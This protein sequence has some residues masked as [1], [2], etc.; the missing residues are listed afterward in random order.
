M[1]VKMT[2]KD[3]SFIMFDEVKRIQISDPNTFYPSPPV[4][5]FHY[6][7]LEKFLSKTI[8]PDTQLNSEDYR[9][10]K[11]DVAIGVADEE[12]PEKRKILFSGVISENERMCFR[13]V[14]FVHDDTNYIL[15][16]QHPV[17]ICSDAGKTIEVV[18]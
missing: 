16:T 5:C 11:I 17:Y 1:L 7:E 12:V 15:Y 3:G 14:K 13:I 9:D 8:N 2:Q 4:S 6:E 10:V 18:R